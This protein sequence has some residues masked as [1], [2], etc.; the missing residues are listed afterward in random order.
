[1]SVHSCHLLFDHFQFA[2]IHG[3]DI[4]GSCAVLFFAALDLTPITGHIR[5]WALFLHWPHLFFLEWFLRSSPVAC[6]APADP[7]VHLSVSFLPFHPVHVSLFVCSCFSF[8]F[9]PWT[10][11]E[12]LKILCSFTP[13]YWALFIQGIFSCINTTQCSK[14]RKFNFDIAL[15]CAQ[16]SMLSQLSQHCSI[17]GIVWLFLMWVTWGWRFTFF[18][19]DQPVY[20]FLLRRP[21]F[22]HQWDSSPVL[23]P[24]VCKMFEFSLSLG[25]FHLSLPAPSLLM[26]I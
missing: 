9:F 7:G 10:I 26:S 17:S 23:T 20:H 19:Y 13:K 15:L 2:L 18:S 16:L 24:D 5:S 21:P 6:W 22:L 8:F 1:M 3:P 25:L 12:Q 14:L 11:S 4:P